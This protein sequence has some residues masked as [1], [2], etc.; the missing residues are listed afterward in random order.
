[1][2]FRYVRLP[3]FNWVLVPKK[4]VITS[5]N[6]SRVPAQQIGCAWMTVICLFLL[7]FQK[8]SLSLTVILCSVSLVLFSILH[9]WSEEIFM[10]I[11]SVSLHGQKWRWRSFSAGY[12]FLLNTLK[13]IMV[14]VFNQNIIK[15][16]SVNLKRQTI[17]P[18]VFGSKRTQ[19]IFDSY[20]KRRTLC[21]PARKQI[22]H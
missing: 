11:G 2:S 9:S 10:T 5:L 4:C 17:N 13:I 1:M 12:C 16:M 18:I 15:Y 20:T 21:S 6:S 8:S 7:C 3:R 22:V 14:V 19:S